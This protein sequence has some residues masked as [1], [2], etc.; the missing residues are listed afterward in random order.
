MKA[1]MLRVFSEIYTRTSLTKIPSKED[2]KSFLMEYL[3]P[4]D[5]MEVNGRHLPLNWNSGDYGG[6]S[7]GKG[8]NDI[9][10]A[11]T[12]LI[13]KKLPIRLIMNKM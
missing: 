6:Y 8:I 2:F 10:E 3:N 11:I 12:V 7:S 9:K 5:I 4:Q 1:A 13:T